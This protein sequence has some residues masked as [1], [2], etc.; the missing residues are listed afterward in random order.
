MSVF[1][2][3]SRFA[4]FAATLLSGI[5]ALG[6]DYVVVVSRATHNDPGWRLVIDE[7]V[8]KHQAEVVQYDAHVSEALPALCKSFPRYACFVA[9]S[10]ESG[11]QM[12]ADVHR[13]TRKLDDD[14]YADVI[15]GILTGYDAAN[16]LEIAKE[17]TPLVIRRVA[18]G[19][20]LA[21]DRVTEGVWYCELE[22]NRMVRKSAGGAAEQSRGPSDTT[23]ALAAALTDEKADLGTAKK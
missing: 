3:T 23:A 18:S 10:K 21:M 13:L 14:P 15:W 17:R 11:R 19:T 1:R 8:D 4:V 2:T 20:E 6:A 9:T 22:K 12:V 7:L 5:A 16:A